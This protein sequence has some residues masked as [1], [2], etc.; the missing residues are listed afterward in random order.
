MGEGGLNQIEQWG[1][2]IPRTL[3]EAEKPGL[4]DLRIEEIGIRV[5][6]TV[7]LVKLGETACLN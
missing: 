6:V 7:S 2:G 5:R 4:P 3:H 1:S